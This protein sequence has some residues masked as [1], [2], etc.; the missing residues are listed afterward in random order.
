MKKLKL[1]SM[2]KVAKKVKLTTTQGN[3][4]KFQE[5]GDVAFQILVKSQL[6]SQPIDIEELMTYSITPVPH[7]LGTPDGYTAKTNKAAS[8]HYLTCEVSDAE[9]PSASSGET[10]FIEDGNAHFHTLKD[11]PATFKGICLKLLDQLSR[12]PDVV[13][14][15]DMYV[16]NSIKSQERQRRGSSAKI[17]LE[18]INT[19]KP[20]D[21]KVFLQ[22]DENKKQ[23][24][25]LM[26]RIWGCPEAARRLQGRKVILVVEGVSFQLSSSDGQS[27]Q[28]EEIPHLRSNQEETDTRV[29]LYLLYAKE[30]GYKQSV[31][32]SPDSDIF[33]ILLHFAQKLR[34]LI[35]Y[36]DTG[37]G[38]SRRLL[39]FSDIAEDLG[40]RYCQSLLGIYCFTGEDCNCAF[41]GKGKKTPLKKLEKKPRYQEC[42]AELGD[43]WEVSDRLVTKLE[44][45]VCFLYGFPRVK[46]V[47]TV[48]T[49]MLRKM[50]GES[51]AIR[52]SSKVDLS[53]LP[54]CKQSL[55]PHIKR[56]NYRA[57]QWKKA[58]I[59]IQ[60]I[61]PPTEHGWTKCEDYIEPVWS[62][63]PVL[64]SC[65][66]D[67]LLEITAEEETSD[68]EDTDSAEDDLNES[69]CSGL[70][71]YES[72]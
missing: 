11:L 22:N 26:L 19:R 47:N 64:P 12:K 6:V 68:G 37:S 21:F 70:D 53:K 50:V 30:H 59:P 35:I 40:P 5:Q 43:S 20:S 63:G 69:D 57:A 7:C 2:E 17:I 62:E 48:R 31:V 14:S 54:P 44:E 25:K 33:F 61:P 46:E 8:V 38:A 42:F 15:T 67:I 39:K 58:D 56:A 45:F 52:S 65:L 66:E 29:V 71:D 51:G 41:K 27:V 1:K 32:H 23:L 13:F 4:I 10:L 28:Q 55:V 34:P 24:C 9:L 60:E 36:F 18:G 72:D 3:V 16:E 49:L